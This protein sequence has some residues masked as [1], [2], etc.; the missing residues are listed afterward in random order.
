MFMKRLLRTLGIILLT[1]ILIPIAEAQEQG[2]RERI[3]IAYGANSI[4]FLV[5]F[6][7]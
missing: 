3:R 2:A 4:S 5:M 6:L 7:V 1:L